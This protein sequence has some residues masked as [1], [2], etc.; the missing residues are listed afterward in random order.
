MNTRNGQKKILAA[1]LIGAL[2]AQP[3]AAQ[4]E[5]NLEDL[6]RDLRQAGSLPAGFEPLD[7]TDIAVGEASRKLEEAEA[8]LLKQ[9]NSGSP[10]AARAVIDDGFGPN[11]SGRTNEETAEPVKAAVGTRFLESVRPVDA[12]PAIESPAEVVAARVVAQDQKLPATLPASETEEPIISP[13][14]SRKGKVEPEAQVA[15]IRRA[16]MVSTDGPSADE[17]SVAELQDLIKRHGKI[18]ADL[19]RQ[20]D[21]ASK[22]KRKADDLSSQLKNSEA[23]VKALEQELTE[24]RNRLIISE[25]EVERLSGLMVTTVRSSKSLAKLGTAPSDGAAVAPRAAAIVPSRRPMEAQ[26]AEE[27]PVATV[28]VEKANLRTG[29]GAEHSPLMS[30]TR[31]TRL[32]V[33]IRRGEWYRVVSP[34]GTRAW[35]SADVVAFGSSPQ[36]SP[37]RTVKVKGFDPS[38]E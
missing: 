6:R 34:S 29:P 5:V 16:A 9:I 22:Y 10:E 24:A 11:P 35:V 12:E 15:T 8:Q 13:K 20:T 2:A 36:G 37:S 32:L 26:P 31:G 23:K 14:P 7:D 33:E 30:V 38:L 21:A 18:K 17:D 25:T 27:M 28:V 4:Q 1:L 3:V 19:Q